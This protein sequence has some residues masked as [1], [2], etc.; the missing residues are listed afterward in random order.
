M[1]NYPKVTI[2]IPT[3]KQEEYIKEAVVSALAQDYQNLEVIVTDDCSPDNTYG[4]IVQFLS[5]SRFKYIR[6]SRNLGRVG[7]YHNTLYNYATGDWVVNLDGDDYYTS[8]TFVSEAMTD[9]VKAQKTGHDVVAY[10]F[11][12]PIG[13]ALR[14][15]RGQRISPTTVVVSGRDYFLN[16]PFVGRFGH[17]RT[18]Y[19]RKRAMEIGD[20]YT[21]TYLA[22][23]FHTI[24]RIIM[25]GELCLNQ[26][27]I[28]FWR[29]HKDN[30]TIKEVGEQY[31]QIMCAYDDIS[32][33][34]KQFCSAEELAIWRK[35]MNRN[36]LKDYAETYSCYRKN[37]KAVILL[38][39][40]FEW[41][42]WYLRAWYYFL[43]KNFCK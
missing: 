24:I 18:L 17:L 12:H 30:A 3:Y 21:K 42:R 40:V 36:A 31:E 37:F 7:N 5:D 26:K 20:C 10:I 8:S 27:S 23:D 14:L 33:F 43:F 4:Q 16:Y 25:T 19:S 13:A 11:R 6:N 39:R 29:A 34:A 41:K 2:M 35:A 1:E 38:L 15:C 9:I 32:S 22:S 28:S